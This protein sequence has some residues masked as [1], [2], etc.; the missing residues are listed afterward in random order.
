MSLADQ[1]RQFADD[2]EDLKNTKKVNPRIKRDPDPE[3]VIIEGLKA[4]G[5]PY[6]VAKKMFDEHGAEFIARKIFLFQ[7]RQ[8]TEYAKPVK[9]VVGWLTRAIQYDYNEP[10]HFIDWLRQQR[11]SDNSK[12]PLAFQRLI[13]LT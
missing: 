2:L 12:Q 7:Y 10:D 5:I 1:L 11:D 13:Q 6:T 3:T 4:V 8:K 9:S